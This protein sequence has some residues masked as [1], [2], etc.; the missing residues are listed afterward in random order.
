MLHENFR[1]INDSFT[2]ERVSAAEMDSLLETGWRHFGTE[3]FR[4]NIG[5]VADELRFVIPLRIR[6]S[7]FQPGKSQRRVLKASNGLEISIAPAEVTPESEDLFHRH[8]LRFDHSIPDSIYDFISASPATSPCDGRQLTVR[9][10]GRLIAVSY[11]D[12]GERSLSGI[13]ASF[14]PDLSSRS[15]GILTMLLEIKFAIETGREFY[16][17]GYCYRGKSFYDYK[18]RFRGTEAFD[19]YDKWLAHD[20]S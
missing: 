15:L 5:F 2:A 8:K 10:N 6:V 14:D 13:Y 17:Q 4:Y 9:E 3:F 12:A 19:W 20:G 1:L 7:Q 18:K 11:F 16:Y